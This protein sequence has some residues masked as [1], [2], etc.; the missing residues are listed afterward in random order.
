MFNKYALRAAVALSLVAAGSVS[1]ETITIATVNN[2]DMIRIEVES[3][4]YQERV[5]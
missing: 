4:K 3:H 5:R 1:A 2:G